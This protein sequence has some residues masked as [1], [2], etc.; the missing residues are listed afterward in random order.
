MMLGRSRLSF[1]SVEVQTSQSQAIIGTPLLVPDP[2]KVIVR[3]GQITNQM[4]EA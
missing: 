4:Y 3:G 2:R 1:T